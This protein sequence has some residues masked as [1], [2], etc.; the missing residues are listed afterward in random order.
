MS[1]RGLVRRLA[2]TG[3]ATH[4]LLASIGGLFLS[5]LPFGGSIAGD[6]ASDHDR[7]YA[8]KAAYLV[9]LPQFID[10]PSAEAPDAVF[11]VWVIGN[12][13]FGP[14]LDQAFSGKTVLGRTF[15]V[16]RS[17]D[18]VSIGEGEDVDIVFL[19]A[20]N[21]ES[22]TAWTEQLGS[23]PILVTSEIPGHAALNGIVGFYISGNNVRFEINRKN[24]D[25][26]G[27]RI[28]SQLLDLARVVGEG[29]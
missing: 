10:W 9:N 20:Q 21:T 1:R 2:G 5:A 16:H 18:V 12:D 8:V 29:T 7:E 14:L 4:I 6:P 17:P 13:P 24:A 23:G 27:L 11:D 26:R 28:S 22:A 3:T 15:A 19:A 25:A